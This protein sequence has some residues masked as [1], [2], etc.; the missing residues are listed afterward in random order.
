MY[1]ASSEDTAKCNFVCLFHR[2]V[3]LKVKEIVSRATEG[4]VHTDDLENTLG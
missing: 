2:M 4:R 3:V 1:S